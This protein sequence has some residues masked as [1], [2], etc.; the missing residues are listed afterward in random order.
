VLG[1]CLKRDHSDQSLDGD[2]AWVQHYALGRMHVGGTRTQLSTSTNTKKDNLNPEVDF[3]RDRTLVDHSIC[4][5]GS[6]IARYRCASRHKA[7]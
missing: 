1:H 7:W 2:Q 4:E 3:L 5:S 6:A